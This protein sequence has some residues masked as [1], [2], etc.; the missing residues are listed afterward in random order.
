M[1]PLVVKFGG[2]SVR[3]A[4]ALRRVRDIV[5][6]RAAAH[7][8]VVVLSATSGTT[9]ALLQA[10]N[11]RDADAVDTIRSRHHA[12]VDGLVP[13]EAAHADVDSLCNALATYLRGMRLLDET[14]EQSLDHVVAYGELLSTTILAHACT[15]IGLRTAFLDVRTIM[16][17]DARHR[18]AAV[19]T[20]TVHALAATSLIPTL[21]DHQIVVTQGFIGSTA[22]G[23]TTTL[24]RGGSDYSAAILGAAVNAE[25]IEIWTDV[26]GIYTTDPRLA[27]NARPIPRMGF[28]EVRDLALYGAKVLHPDTIAPAVSAGIPVHVRNTFAPEE[29]GTVITAKA[30]SDTLMHAVTLVRA[31][32]L[33]RWTGSAG[34]HFEKALLGWSYHDGGACVV[35]TTDPSDR[36]DAEVAVA[37]VP[38]TLQDAAVLAVCGPQASSAAAV[39]LVSK[40]IAQYDVFAVLGGISSST[41]FVVCAAADAEV[42]LQ[43]VH[44]CIV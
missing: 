3:D 34:H 8:C 33:V 44:D 36:I 18:Q 1:R 2:T 29:R 38:H 5:T 19:D 43:A 9:D 10:A 28:D 40:A 21:R 13:T 26:S 31:C 22:E 11:A 24:G 35:R 41:C 25:A 30:P 6:V 16:R 4:D 15:A 17:T 42:V 23:V 14:T 12:I 39:A 7:P 37:N 32:T 27:S 20:Q